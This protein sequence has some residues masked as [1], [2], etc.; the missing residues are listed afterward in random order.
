[1]DTPVLKQKNWFRRHKLLTGTVIVLVLA[2][3]WEVG[4]QRY[5]NDRPA[6]TPQAQSKA[7]GAA[8]PGAGAKAGSNGNAN[9]TAAGSPVPAPTPTAAGLNNKMTIAYSKATTQP[10]GSTQVTGQITNNQSS[11]HSANIQAIFYDKSGGVLGTA[12]GTTTD[13]GPDKTKTFTLTTTQN[14]A[15]YVRMVVEVSS[16]F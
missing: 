12:K 10:N 8:S 14:V 16:I 1:M 6:T 7:G 5:A 4:S 11:T 13:I 15:D 3:I 9:G 2:L